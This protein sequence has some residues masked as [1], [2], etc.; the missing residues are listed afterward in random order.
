M[1]RSLSFRPELGELETDDRMTLQAASIVCVFSGVMSSAIEAFA[2]V[3]RSG[4]SR[5]FR[6]GDRDGDELASMAEVV[7]N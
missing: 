3:L 6:W 4:V 2:R 1:F 7:D 5:S